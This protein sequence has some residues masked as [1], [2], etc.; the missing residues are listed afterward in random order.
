MIIAIVIAVFALVLCIIAVVFALERKRCPACSRRA[1]ALRFFQSTKVGDVDVS[2][3]RCR[4]CKTEWRSYNGKDMIARAA[5]EAGATE[6][7]PVAKVH[8]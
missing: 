2:H 6:P 8:R 4:R 7:L 5:F 1:L 3:F